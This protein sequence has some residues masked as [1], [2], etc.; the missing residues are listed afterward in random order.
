MEYYFK[1]ADSEYELERAFRLRYEVYCEEKKWLKKEDYP[2]GIENDEYDDKAVHLVAF[3]EDFRLV[4]NIRILRQEDFGK[5]PFEDHP[6]LSGR[7]ITF[8]AL[9]ELSRFVIRTNGSSLML[10]QGLL[11]AVY[12]TVVKLGI[13]NCIDICEPSLIRLVSRFKVYFEP[14]APP[15]MYY[16]GF[17]QPALLDIKAMKEKWRKDKECWAYYHEENAVLRQLNHAV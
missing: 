7:Q 11:R 16:G 13:E 8:P 5:L 17:T 9:A 4:G 10:A 6:S 15:C 1:E 3:D 12:Q 2:D 14:L